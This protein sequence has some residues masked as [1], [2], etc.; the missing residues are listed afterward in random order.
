MDRFS[1][2]FHQLI[3]EKILHVQWFPPHLQCVAIYTILW[4]SKIQKC[5]WLW[6]HPQQTIDMFLAT[7]RGL[8]L[9]FN[10]SQGRRHVFKGAMAK[11]WGQTVHCNKSSE[12]TERKYDSVL[13]CYKL[14]IN[15]PVVGR[16]AY[17]KNVYPMQLHFYCK[18]SYI[19]IWPWLS[20]ND[21]TSYCPEAVMPLG[22]LSCTATTDAAV[23]W[24]TTWVGAP[25]IGPLDVHGCS[26]DRV[27]IPDW[28]HLQ[29]LAYRCLGSACIDCGLSQWQRCGSRVWW[30]CTTNGV[31]AYGC[32]V[33]CWQEAQLV[34][35]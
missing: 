23:P 16:R 33:H 27:I 25:T 35:G 11:S 34:L 18:L 31:V 8:D 22:L 1:K 26:P 4:K 19:S 29:W 2:F 24:T 21:V 5:Y 10:S 7:L 28:L 32:T 20:V 30:D 6:Q 15:R 14:G 3:R 12:A 17:R 9:T 13:A